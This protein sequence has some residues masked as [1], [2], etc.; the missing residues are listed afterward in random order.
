MSDRAKR[1]GEVVITGAALGAVRGY[2]K[3]LRRAADNITKGLQGLDSKVARQAGQSARWSGASRAVA[4]AIKTDP[5]MRSQY[6]AGSPSTRARISSSYNQGAQDLGKAGL[7][8][9]RNSAR[10]NAIKGAAV[11]GL[12]YAAGRYASRVKKD[13]T[14]R[15]PGVAADGRLVKAAAVLSMLKALPKPPSLKPIRSMQMNKPPKPMMGQVSAP[16]HLRNTLSSNNITSRAAGSLTGGGM[17][18]AAEE[19]PWDK[20]NPKEAKGKSKTLTPEQKSRA[21]ARAAA[22]GRPYPNWIDNAHVAKTAMLRGFE[23]ELQKI[24]ARRTDIYA[25]KS[26][27]DG[28]AGGEEAKERKRKLKKQASETPAWTRSEGKS[29]TGGLN[30]KGVQSYREANPGSKLKMAVTK[31]PSKIK[32]GSSEDKRRKSFCARM[33]GMPGPMHDKSG[34]PTRK[35]LALDKW[36]C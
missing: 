4:K 7:K 8:I 11:A 2:Y 23:D 24:A 6:L 36:N 22:N 13:T 29:K 27:I 12:I 28:H 32:P 20:K 17:L 26:L 25:S 30:R 33:G 31:D 15:P 14:A 9:I 19:A 34:K 3:G 5:A 21:K 18:K 35:K 16:N 10:N 1:Y